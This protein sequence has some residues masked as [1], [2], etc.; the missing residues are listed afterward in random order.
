MRAV[1]KT[2]RNRVTIASLELDLYLARLDEEMKIEEFLEEN[3]L[4][5]NKRR[6]DYKSPHK[7]EALWDQFCTCRISGHQK[8][9]QQQLYRTRGICSPHLTGLAGLWSETPC[10]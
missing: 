3:D 8:W 4:I 2:H 6:M 5:Y 7:C 9:T 1:L 10:N